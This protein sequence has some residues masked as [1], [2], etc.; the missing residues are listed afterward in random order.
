MCENI[1]IYKQYVIKK[2]VKVIKKYN[3]DYG[4][5]CEAMECS[6]A[7]MAANSLK[8]P[9]ISIRVI[10][11]NE[12]K[13]QPYDNK[14]DILSQKLVINIIDELLKKQIL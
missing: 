6:G 9:L 10:S 3:K 1:A 14:T 13:N 4:I 12:I 5:L 11:N 7:Y 2:Y 8:T